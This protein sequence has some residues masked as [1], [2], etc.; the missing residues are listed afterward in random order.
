MK[1]ELVLGDQIF[2]GT[3]HINTIVFFLK[4]QMKA[5][6]AVGGNTVFVFKNSGTYSKKSSTSQTSMSIF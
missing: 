6:A 5:Q 1:K 3:Y 4:T 2:F